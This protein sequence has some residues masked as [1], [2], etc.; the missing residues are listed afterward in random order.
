MKTVDLIVPVFNE[1]ENI[2]K[3]INAIQTVFEGIQYDYKIILVNDGSSDKTLEVIKA[4]ANRNDKINYISF[5]R[6]FGHQNALKAGLDKSTADCA[7]SLDGDMQHPPELIPA[8]IAKWEEGY[9]VVYT[10]RKEGGKEGMMKKTTSSWFYQV[11]NSMADLD[12]EEGTADFR[13]VSKQVVDVLRD[14]TEHELFFRGLVKW[15]GFSQIGIEYIPNERLWGKS[16]YTLNKM[17]RF[18]LTGITS[19]STKPLYVAAYLGFFFSIASLL[20]F[21]YALYSYFFGTT[22]SGWTSVIV[23]IAFF[24]GLQL[25]ILGII[26]LY[27]GKVFMQVKHRPLY[28]IKE[29]N[30]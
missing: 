16:K 3:L 2:G 4:L 25:C 6:N 8:I 1:Q 13:L 23:T 29:S 12:M 30:I 15:M 19:F 27:L 22:L 26:G 9:D 21:P 28:I 11:M 10:I 14:L 5:S 24:G 18:A 17:V 7:I 20:Y